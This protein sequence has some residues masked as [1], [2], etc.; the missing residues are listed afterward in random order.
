[1]FIEIRNPFAVELLN[2][3]VTLRKFTREDAHAICN[4]SARG[5]AVDRIDG[6]HQV[7]ESFGEDKLRAF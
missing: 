4:G 1:M 3:R 5:R 7:A 2:Y 6:D